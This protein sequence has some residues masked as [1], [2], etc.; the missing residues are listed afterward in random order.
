MKVFGM[1]EM[2][3]EKE[4]DFGNGEFRARLSQMVPFVMELLTHK[5]CAFWYRYANTMKTCAKSGPH[6]K[7]VD[8]A[9]KGFTNALDL[10]DTRSATV[11]VVYSTLDIGTAETDDVF[12]M[13]NIQ[14]CMTVTTSATIH[15][16]PAVTHMGIFRSPLLSADLKSLGGALGEIGTVLAKTPD[17]Y[18]GKA[19]KGIS[20]VL[21]SFA[22]RGLVMFLQGRQPQLMITAPLEHMGGVLAEV[23]KIIAVDKTPKVVPRQTSGLGSSLLG[24][25]VRPR[26]TVPS[27][28]KKGSS[29]TLGPSTSSS[30]NELSISSND[31]GST[32]LERPIGQLEFMLNRSPMNTSLRILYKD[33]DWTWTKIE[34]GW[35][36]ELAFNPSHKYAATFTEFRVLHELHQ[37]I[38]MASGPHRATQGV[39]K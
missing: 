28:V 39:L 5:N 29:P 32:N 17:F 26:P 25:I 18:K 16:F 13:I 4:Q 21:H 2:V 9:I 23:G 10:V 30:K 36:F 31:S 20:L 3:I 12:K 27:T 33:A 38:R 11:F 37:D 14:M 22:A 6:S 34:C 1:K 24:P 8:T 15:D 7:E 35:L 19:A